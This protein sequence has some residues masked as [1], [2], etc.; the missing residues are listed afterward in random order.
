MSL[1]ILGIISRIFEYNTDLLLK[2][3]VLLACG[4]SVIAA[5]LWFERRL[6]SHPRSESTPFLP[7]Q[8]S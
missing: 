3:G 4:T 5:G 2:A 8:L 1:L 7:E 6:L